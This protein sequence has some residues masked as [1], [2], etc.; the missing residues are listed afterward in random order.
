MSTPPYYGFVED[1]KI[2]CKVDG[3]EKEVAI[4]DLRAGTL[5]KTSTGDFRPVEKIGTRTL[6]NPGHSDRIPNRLY[7]LSKSAYPSLTEDLIT[8][9]VQALLVSDATDAER[10]QM[11][12]IRGRITVTD[13]KFCYPCAADE[14]A[15]P[16]TTAGSVTVFSFSIAHPIRMMTYGVYAN[17]LLVE[18]MPSGT[19]ANPMISL[20]Q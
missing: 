1:T 20:L 18:P 16:F 12:A 2:T 17:G 13:K 15:V 8:T 3:K 9:G 11:V 4:Q 14:K 10:R 5:V 7:T 6:N 19:M